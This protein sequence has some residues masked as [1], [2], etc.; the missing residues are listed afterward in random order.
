VLDPTWRRVMVLRR[1]RLPADASSEPAGLADSSVAFVIDGDFNHD[2]RADRALVG[3]Y[4]T[5]DGQFGRFFLILTRRRG[6]WTKAFLSLDRGRPGFGAI[7]RDRDHLLWLA[8]M[9]CDS[10][11][12]IAWTG[13]EY[14][15]LPAPQDTQ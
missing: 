15:T 5:D 11:D 13:R 8:C 2:G 6:R 10:Y 7:L 4:E 3:T 12:T 1:D 14:D 9:D